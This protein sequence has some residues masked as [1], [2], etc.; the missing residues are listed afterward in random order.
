MFGRGAVASPWILERCGICHPRIIS[1][2]SSSST[3]ASWTGYAEIMSGDRNT[4]FK[5]KELWYYFQ[6]HFPGC[7][8]ELKK[9]KKAQKLSD[10]RAAVQAMFASGRFVEDG[11]RNPAL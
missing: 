6:C 8:K 2:L 10:Y 5:M 1:N 3:I 4:L 7:E 9:I 11:F